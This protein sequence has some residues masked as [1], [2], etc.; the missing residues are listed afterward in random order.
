[1]EDARPSQ[2]GE[3]VDA[4]PPKVL[5]ST[6]GEFEVRWQSV[7]HFAAREATCRECRSS[8]GVA[9][10][11]L[12]DITEVCG[13]DKV[14]VAPLSTQVAAGHSVSTRAHSEVL[15]DVEL[16]GVSHGVHDEANFCSGK[17][18]PEELRP[19]WSRM[20]FATSTMARSMSIVS[21]EVFFPSR[22]LPPPS[23]S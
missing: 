19:S 4:F 5:Y 7:V 17:Q 3:P 2:C 11:H 14:L 8:Q 15:V 23:S 22:P 16:Q 1:M 9:D 6:L 12:V 21:G 13:R 20:A 10:A 18:L